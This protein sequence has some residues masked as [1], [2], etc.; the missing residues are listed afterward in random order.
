VAEAS[1]QHFERFFQYGL[2]LAL[3]FGC[4]AV[5]KPFFTPILFSLVIAVS[6]WPYFAV[7]RRLLRGR[8]GVGALIG[9]LAVTLLIIGPAAMLSVAAVD[10]VSWLSEAARRWFEEGAST[11]PEWLGRLPWIG[12]QLQDYWRRLFSSSVEL[13]ALL[14]RYSE[15]MR[16][17]ALGAGKLLGAGLVQ[18]AFAIFLLFFMYR[19]GERL[20]GW[21]RSCAQ[22]VIGPSSGELLE[23]AQNTIVGVMIG[24]LGT[25]L[26]QAM[27]AAIGFLIAGV[28]GA[29]GL[30]AITFALS[31]VPIGPP[32]VWGGAAIWLFNQGQ[33]GWAIF[34]V[35]YGLLL[36]STVDN[37]LK[38]YLISRSSH[39]PFALTLMGV[40]GGVLAFGFMGVFI[41]P[42]L[43]ALAVNLGAR[44]LS[45]RP[46]LAT[47]PTVI[48][49]ADGQPGASAPPP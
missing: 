49:A 18:I 34:M 2:M 25:A 13:R 5:L 32:L 45:S 40:I 33:T 21:L 28:P 30:A 19:D 11:P 9:C 41:G 15:P 27:V 42:T 20:G 31:M 26:A 44:W 14:L 47:T 39:L 24:V 10:G 46:A 43:L 1:E 22:G 12:D 36:I 6:T 4:L 16:N 35:L 23:T 3:V 7:L 38:P 8:A 37:V 17:F 48:L 29:V